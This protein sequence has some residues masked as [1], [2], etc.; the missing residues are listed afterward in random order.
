MPGGSGIRGR[1]VV[2]RRNGVNLAGVRTKSVT[3]NGSIIDVTTD[4]DDGVRRLMDQPGQVDVSISVSGV[5]L[6]EVL[7]NEALGT[8][9]RVSQTQF[10]Y[11]GFEGSPANTHGWIGDF[12]ISSYSESGEYQGVVTF[13]A[14]FESAGTV[15]YTPK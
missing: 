5:V 4:D 1:A 9:D 2:I 6:N 10:I 7:R 14:T 12:F 8:S 15:T 13:E 3:I 11:L